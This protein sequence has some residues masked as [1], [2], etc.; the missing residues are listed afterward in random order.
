VALFISLI[1]IFQEARLSSMELIVNLVAVVYWIILLLIIIRQL[2]GAQRMQIMSYVVGVIS[3]LIG[4]VLLI[5]PFITTVIS[6]PAIVVFSLW[7]LSLGVFDLLC[8]QKP[9]LFQED[10][11]ESNV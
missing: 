8:I 9:D 5:L 7:M 2:A 6:L 4:I 1:T 10:F 3:M 11:E